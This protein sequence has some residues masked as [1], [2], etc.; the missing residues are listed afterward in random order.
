M[1]TYWSQFISHLSGG[2]Y[3]DIIHSLFALII[4]VLFYSFGSFFIKK[5]IEN[6]YQKRQIL[7]NFRNICVIILFLIEI[8]LWSGEIKTLLISATAIFAAFMVA[9]KDLIISFIGSL[10][11]T[12]NKLFSL[13]NIIQVGDIKGK[14]LD[15]NLFFTKLSISDGLGKKELLIPNKFFI[16]T[17]FI[18]YSNGF[19]FTT[20]QLELVIPKIEKIKEISDKLEE[21]IKKIA[22]QQEKKYLEFNNTRHKENIFIEPIKKFYDIKFLFDSENSKVIIQLFLEE[23]VKNEIEKEIISIYF[24]EMR[25]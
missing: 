13:G 19:E 9:F 15:K 2:M 1:I 17:S 24:E 20:L 7:V 11:I 3:T 12:S 21:K 18:N 10:F 14:V 16:D 4:I 23:K 22:E 5:R 25:K 6:I 8:F